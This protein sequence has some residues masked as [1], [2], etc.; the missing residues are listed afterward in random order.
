M[1]TRVLSGLAM[2]PLAAIVWIGG[3]ALWIA[4]FALSVLAVRE[5]FRSFEAADIRPS[6]PVAYFSAAA[7]YAVGA[8]APEN[9]RLC[10]FWFVLVI[11]LSFLYLFK[12]D[13]RKLADGMATLTGIFYVC[14][15]SFHVPLAGQLPQYGLMVWLIFLTAFGTDVMAYF[16]GRALGKHK[17][18]PA[19]SP[20][21][22]V[23]GAIGGAAGSVILCTLFGYFIL[24]GLLVHC[25]VIGLLG[26]VVSQLGDL[27]ASVFKRKL[28]V[29]DYGTL[30]PGHG[31]VLDRID[32]VLFTAPMV[33]YYAVLVIPIFAP[34][35]A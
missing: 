21:K 1:K 26:G 9:L 17:L 3:W 8:L 18:C 15:F 14:F 12:T 2:L 29:K 32:S 23:E 28:G 6:R 11:F 35:G 7:L 13:V 16:T 4:C 5:L 20:K 25:A 24:P 19:I 10:L 30:I 33:Y 27:T 34:H 31:G 22:T